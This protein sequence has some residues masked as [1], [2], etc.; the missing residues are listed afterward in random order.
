MGST[1]CADDLHEA[2]FVAERLSG[3]Q[4]VQHEAQQLL[5]LVGDV[6]CRLIA[7]S[8]SSIQRRD[9]I[10]AFEAWPRAKIALLRYFSK[11]AV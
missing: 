1:A 8:A 2:R 3:A 7:T 11:G 5:D 4:T 10:P 6:W 9:Q